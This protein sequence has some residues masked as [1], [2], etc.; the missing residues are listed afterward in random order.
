LAADADVAYREVVVLGRHGEASGS[1]RQV[2]SVV[3]DGRPLLRSDL[4]LGPRWPAGQGPVGVGS[5]RVVGT[6]LLVG[7][8]TARIMA[9]GAATEP[10]GV[11]ARVGTFALAPEATLVVAL[12]DDVEPVLSAV[13]LAG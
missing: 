12:A 6:L 4:G 8:A 7:L 10:P 13:T 2:L 3:R 11:G 1:L 5:A 9:T